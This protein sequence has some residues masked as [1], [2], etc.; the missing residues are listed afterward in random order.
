MSEEF[1]KHPILNSP[2]ARPA[3][4]S[5]LDPQVHGRGHS[6]VIH[7]IEQ[8]LQRQETNGLLVTQLRNLRL[9][10]GS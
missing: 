6:M 1:F 7:S 5:E 3:W 4:H 8:V 9:K 10:I 2:Y